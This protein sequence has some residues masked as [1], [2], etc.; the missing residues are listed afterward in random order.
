MWSTTAH[1]S[2]QIGAVSGNVFDNVLVQI[3]PSK[4]ESLERLEG[5]PLSRLEDAWQIPYLGLEQAMH[6][7]LR[8]L[9]V[10]CLVYEQSQMMR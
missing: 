2:P 5:T 8:F 7:G 4:L 6:L 9:R 3:T 10:S 1:N